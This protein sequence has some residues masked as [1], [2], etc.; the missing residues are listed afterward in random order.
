MASKQ[1]SGLLTSDRRRYLKSAC[2][3]ILIPVAARAGRLVRKSVNGSYLVERS[4]L[5][6]QR[7]SIL[8]QAA[9][10]VE[11]NHAAAASTKTA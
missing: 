5:R 8:S 4:I 3:R 10:V 6:L 2:T 7:V 9:S 1:L 11:I